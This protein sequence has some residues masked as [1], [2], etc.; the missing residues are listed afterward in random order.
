[1][2]PSFVFDRIVIKRDRLVLKYYGLWYVQ[3][4]PN[5]YHVFNPCVISV[6]TLVMFCVV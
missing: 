3:M 5:I 6:S 2:V 4:T 1:M